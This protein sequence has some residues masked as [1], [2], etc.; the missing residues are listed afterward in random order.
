MDQTVEILAGCSNVEDLEQYL[1]HKA[2][3]KELTEKQLLYN[4]SPFDINEVALDNFRYLFRFEKEDIF[5]LYRALKMPERWVTSDRHTIGGVEGLCLLLRRFA[6][7]NRLMELQNEFGLQYSTLSKLLKHIT[8]FVY[9]RWSKL[10]LTFGENKWLTR[11]FLQELAAIVHAKG[12]P[13]TNC[14]GF[15]DGTARSICRTTKLQQQVYSG[16]K[17]AHCLKFQA[18]TLPNGIILHLSNPYPGR[19]H[20]AFIL[21]DTKIME[22]LRLYAPSLC[23]YGDE[24]YPL[25]L[26]LIRPYSNTNLTPQQQEF[27][28]N[29][30]KVRQC[31]EWSFGKI[32]QQFAFVDFKKNQKLF[33]QPVGK[34][35][36]VATLLTNAHTCFYGSTT[37]KYFN[38]ESPDIFQYFQ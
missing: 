2:L 9:Q 36:I 23:I 16:H 24:G 8:N 33:L 12:A 7:P 17:R 37:S 21:R 34:F 27:N 15:I 5:T 3:Q 14:I 31:V 26:Q 38:V 25:R 18:I 6:Y 13:L 20:D 35:Y 28:R 19:R 22:Q 10:L 1:V 32:T 29:M 4:C 11:E 30:S